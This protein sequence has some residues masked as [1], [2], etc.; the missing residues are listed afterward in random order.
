MPYLHQAAEQ[1]R[2]YDPPQHNVLLVTC[3]DLRLIDNI[4]EFMN[5]DNLCNR[6]D[7]IVFAGAALGAL[8]APGGK[9]E[10]GAP[11]ERPAWHETFKDHLGAAV[12]LHRVK[13]VYIV[14]HR[15]CGAYSKV[16][17]ILDEA[18]GADDELEC[19]AHYAAQLEEFIHQWAADN[20]WPL[21]V[22]KFIM[23]LRGD[24]TMLP[25]VTAKAD[26]P[27][28]KSPKKRGRK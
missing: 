4:V 9:T 10:Q 2:P 25:D 22:H 6:Y 12:E 11:N 16:F 15:G 20:K 23:D 28:R 19:H 5:H 27:Q 14:E 8:G 1:S 21:H 3:M 18:A 7:H 24:M 17:H 13:D 26:R